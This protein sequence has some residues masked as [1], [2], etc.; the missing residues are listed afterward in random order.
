M[1]GSLRYLC[2]NIHDIGFVVGLIRRYMDDPKVSHVK[3]ARRILGC[4][5]GTM[6]SGILFPSNIGGDD[7]VI[8]CYSD[9]D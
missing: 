1:V 4:L 6:N 7:V 3:N 2:N 5:N 9:S 8:T